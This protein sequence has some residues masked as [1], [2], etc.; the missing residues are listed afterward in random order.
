[1]KYILNVF[2]EIEKTNNWN[3][4]SAIELS[5]SIPYSTIIEEGK[6]SK[7]IYGIGYK[8]FQK[9]IKKGTEFVIMFDEQYEHDLPQDVMG[10]I[11]KL[12]IKGHNEM[13]RLLSF[14]FSRFQSSLDEYGDV[15]LGAI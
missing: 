4:Y 2:P 15:E 5:D 7:D 11:A 14:S 6:I 13:F 1:M 9:Y 10:G 12:F 3:N 8:L